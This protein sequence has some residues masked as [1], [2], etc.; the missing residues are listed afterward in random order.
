MKG[1][2]AAAQHSSNDTFISYIQQNAMNA[3]NQCQD[4]LLINTE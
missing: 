2:H 4:F 1:F 3:C